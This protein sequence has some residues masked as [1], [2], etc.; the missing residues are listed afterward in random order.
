MF[1]AR[2]DSVEGSSQ[3]RVCNATDRHFGKFSP[4]P[5]KTSRV[6]RRSSLQTGAMG[7]GPDFKQFHDENPA[8]I[9]ESYA[10]FILR[11][12]DSQ[13]DSFTA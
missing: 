4:A 10:D 1:P 9:L 12:H 5:G 3:L 13:L 2:F 11:L 6:I 8:V 7:S